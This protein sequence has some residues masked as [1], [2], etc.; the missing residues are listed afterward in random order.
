MNLKLQMKLKK[1]VLSALF[2]LLII[3]G[4]N[5]QL[6]NADTSSIYPTE[7]G[8]HQS[9][10]AAPVSKPAMKWAVPFEGYIRQVV[11]D[12]A[13]TLYVL[14]EYHRSMKLTALQGNGKTI[15]SQE[16]TL[17][18][19]NSLYLYNDKFLILTGMR[20]TR[21]T[22]A[23]G[24]ESAVLAKYTSA[25]ELVWENTYQDTD[26]GIKKGGITVDDDGFIVFAG[27]L[28]SLVKGSKYY[29]E[30]IKLIGVN[31]T[32]ETQFNKTLVSSSDTVPVAYSNP[33]IVKGNIYLSTSQGLYIPYSRNAQQAIFNDAKFLKINKQGK[34]LFSTSYKG[35][36]YPAPVYFNNYFYITG[37]PYDKDNNLYIIN[38]AGKITKKISVARGYIG[39]GIAPSVSKEGNIVFG[40]RVYTSSGQLIWSFLPTAKGKTYRYYPIDTITIDSKQNMVF[41]NMDNLNGGN[42]IISINLKTK[43]IN[44]AITV[45][46]DIES[47]TIVGKDGTIYVWGQKLFAYGHL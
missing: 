41:T 21:D 47:P 12:S 6:V 27:T 1:A 20:D 44:W 15:W 17:S 29:K 35:I 16:L 39:S 22:S 37:E 25:G 24:M 10:Y 3:N 23:V 11:I 46:S 45:N 38:A 34:V 5:V 14:S 30:E 42:G 4:I 40:E 13:G 31:A 8:T 18:R 43:K 7:N 2:A 26:V 9:Q 36:N 28:N 19:A 32:G 33:L